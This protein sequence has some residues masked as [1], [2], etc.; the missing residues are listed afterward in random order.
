MINKSVLSDFESL[1]R[2]RVCFDRN[3]TYGEAFA[4]YTKCTA[5][6]PEFSFL[7]SAPY[8]EVKKWIEG[9]LSANKEVRA[10]ADDISHP[11]EAPHKGKD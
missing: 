10:K 1:W 9:E 7:T 5:D 3:L 11:S 4:Q 6:D 2:R 8:P